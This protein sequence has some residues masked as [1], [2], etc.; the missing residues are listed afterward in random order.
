[1]SLY[2]WD[3]LGLL[4]REVALY[5]RL[6]PYVASL[7]FVTYG[8][9]RD[10]AY[11][12]AIPSIEILCN[13][14]SLP[15]H[16]YA[17]LLPILYRTHFEHA[18][19][20]KTNQT[21]GGH[22]ALYLAERYGIPLIARSG[23]DLVFNAEQKLTTGWVEKQWTRWQERILFTGASH[24]VTTT[25]VI[26]DNY[27][28]RHGL[29]PDDITIIPNYVDTKVMRPGAAKR[30]GSVLFV[31]RLAKEKNLFNLVN[32][33]KTLPVE[34]III[35]GGVLYGPLTRY[36][37]AKN[38]NNVRMMG[39]RPYDKVSEALK[40]AELFVLPSH[41]EGHPKALIEAMACG[42]PVIGANSPGIAP[43]LEDNV[44]GILCETDVESIRDAIERLM[45]DADLR[46]RLGRAAR[47]EA[48]NRYSIDNVVQQ[49][50]ALMKK[51]VSQPAPLPRKGA[52][53]RYIPRTVVNLSVRAGLAVQSFLTS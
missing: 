31:G 11:Q 52:T 4:Q 40:S 14:W 16:L 17:V 27:V 48:V 30:S 9:S 8:D 2:R 28:T 5:N 7:S 25:E 39:R 6:R 42:L 36:L 13:R 47:Q 12:D 3:K 43:V 44:T 1:M 53:L 33:V 22:E 15:R 46:D 45:D 38:I 41:Y 18:T 35:G 50:L 29:N 20:L 21:L 32:A 23:A 49:E 37:A 10:L 19:V 24:L 51:M 26:R 34:L